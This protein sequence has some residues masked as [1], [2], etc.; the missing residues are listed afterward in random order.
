M[1]IFKEELQQITMHT[2]WLNTIKF[3]YSIVNVVKAI[4]FSRDRVADVCVVL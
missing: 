1:S 2:F 4:I 3:S